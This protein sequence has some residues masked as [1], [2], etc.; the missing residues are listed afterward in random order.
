MYGR[1]GFG[2]RPPGRGC[3]TALIIIV[4]IIAA[5]ALFVRFGLPRIAAKIIMDGGSLPGIPDEVENVSEEEREEFRN[6]LSEYN[7]SCDTL[8]TLVDSVET[9]EI[10]DISAR[11]NDGSISSNAQLFDEFA[12]YFDFGA[13]DTQKLRE[14]FINKV[15]FSDMQ[16]TSVEIYKNRKLLSFLMPMAKD[17]AKSFIN[18][19]DKEGR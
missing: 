6:S 16:N 4:V 10:V 5:L 19:L 11:V 3:L 9:K 13:A 18:E 12:R 8:K 1:R 2:E 17:M 14:E 15:D 7:M